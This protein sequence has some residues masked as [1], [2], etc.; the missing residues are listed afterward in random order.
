MTTDFTPDPTPDIPSFVR[1]L[2]IAFLQ[3]SLTIAATALGAWGILG[4]K[5]LQGEF[6]QVGIAGG[7]GLISV[8]WTWA[9]AKF[10]HATMKAA[11]AAPGKAAT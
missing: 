8:G 9:H 11:L 3:K 10:T 6:V 4:T 1:T 5:T 2:E 7:L